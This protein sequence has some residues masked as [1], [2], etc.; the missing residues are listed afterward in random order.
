MLCEYLTLVHSMT[1]CMHLHSRKHDQGHIH[2]FSIHL[3]LQSFWMSVYFNLSALLHSIL[4]FR[5][6]LSTHSV[7]MHASRGSWFSADI[8]RWAS[9]VWQ[10]VTKWAMMG[11][12]QEKLAVQWRKQA[13]ASKWRVER[14]RVEEPGHYESRNMR[15]YCWRN[16]QLPWVLKLQERGQGSE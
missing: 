2:C 5:H 8:S 15:K 16:W 12:A 11:H 4:L 3:L 13:R 14:V 1:F 7:P 6:A 9:K 10:H